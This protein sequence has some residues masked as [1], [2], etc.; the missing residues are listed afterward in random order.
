MTMGYKTILLHLDDSQALDRRIE[1][2][3][4]LA[5]DHDAHLIGLYSPIPVHLAWSAE[6]GGRDRLMAT[7][8]TDAQARARLV[9]DRFQQ[10]AGRA[11]L[12]R[13][14]WREAY[15]DP[16][17][18]LTLQARYADLLILGQPDETDS[19]AREAGLILEDVILAAGRPALIVPYIGLLQPIGRRALVAWDAGR[20]ATRAVT[21][22]LPVLARCETVTVVVVDAKPS[23]VGHG[24]LPGTDLAGFLARHGITVD[25]TH[26]GSSGVGVG[27]TL[28]NQAAERNADLVVMGC[29]GHGRLRER[30]LGGATRT[31][32]ASM[33]VPVLMAH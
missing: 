5:L 1:A 15:E 9:R 7:L 10:A 20:E 22:S 16:R 4:Q 29:Y 19:G 33:P 27:A 12:S 30:I 24:D 25:V 23:A 26:V 11:G 6:A 18:S 32:L 2:A 13:I 17:E 8:Q 3:I 14:E 31:I 28:L 21:D